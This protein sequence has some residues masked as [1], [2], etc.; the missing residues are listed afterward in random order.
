MIKPPRR[1]GV[2]PSGMIRRCLRR[3]CCQECSRS[4]TRSRFRSITTKPA[5]SGSRC[6]PAS[7]PIRRAATDRSWSSSRGDR[8]RVLRL[9]D[10][11][12]SG[13]VRLPSGDELTWRRFRQLG[14][15]LG[16][17]DGAE[18]LHYLLEL[19]AHSPGFLHDVEGS[20]AFARNPLYA[21]L[22]E[23]C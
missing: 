17:S 6:S 18:Y 20:V 9:H 16:M 23:A 10:R 1:R 11:I 4:S 21:V 14:Q 8:E 19:P 3:F 2:T 22:H 5:A 7:W 13:A 12:E 15:M